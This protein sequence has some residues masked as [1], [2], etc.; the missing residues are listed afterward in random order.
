[1]TSPAAPLTAAERKRRRRERERSSNALF[2]ER[3]DWQLFC[4]ISTLPQKA[5]CQPGEIIQ[6]VLKELVDNALDHNPDGEVALRHDGDWWVVEDTGPG[7]DPEAAPSLF[8]VNR[9]LLSSKPR[10]L[11]LRGMVGNGLRVVMGAVAATNGALV[12]KTRGRRLE[13]DI[14]RTTGLTRVLS[15][16]AV[17]SRA[18]TVVRIR[19]GAFH[20]SGAHGSQ[21]ARIALSVARHGRTYAGPS[22]PHWCGPRD[23]LRLF[24]HVT[25]RDATVADVCRD[26]GFVIADERLA[27]RLNLDDATDVLTRLQ[28]DHLSIPP[29]KLGFLGPDAFRACYRRCEAD[30]TIVGARIPFVVEAWASC[31]RA[32]RGAGDVRISLPLNRTPA[33][34]ARL[35]RRADAEDLEDQTACRPT[36]TGTGRSEPARPWVRVARSAEQAATPVLHRDRLDRVAGNDARSPTRRSREVRAYP[37]GTW[38][39]PADGSESRRIGD[40]RMRVMPVSHPGRRG[41]SCR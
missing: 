37:G 12:V 11:P 4:D 41:P 35:R 33:I 2:Y 1:V 20:W 34:S 30:A 24:N 19:F 40:A 23:L 25:P 31:H 14:D 9:P 22:S 16:T 29:S 3:D 6:I 32:E 10:R 5:G 17:P 18:G 15:D 21:A 39:R 13:L 27:R 7:I 28:A 26:L 36:E 8:C 38:D